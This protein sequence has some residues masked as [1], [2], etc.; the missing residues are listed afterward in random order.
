MRIANRSAAFGQAASVRDSASDAGV[1]AASITSPA[2]FALLFDRHF[3]PIH[4]YLQRRIGGDLADELAAETFLVAFDRRTNYD[5]SYPSARPWLYGIATN[6][7]RHHRRRERRQLRAY[8]RTGVD[9]VVDALEGVEGRLDA[10]SLGRELARAMAALTA[11]DRDVLL[12]CAWA[13]LSYQ[14]IAQTL[15]LPIGTVRSRLA[16]ARRRTRELLEASGQLEG[17][18][19]L[20]EAERYG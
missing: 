15:A 13:D 1:I 18:P 12:L 14:E 11:R 2:D 4:G 5:R 9:P 19:P 6:L 10:A 17:E 3:D 16:R 8:A 7:L 20:R